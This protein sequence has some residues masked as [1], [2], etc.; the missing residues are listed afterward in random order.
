MPVMNVC[1]LA[2]CDILLLL[3]LDEQCMRSSVVTDGR[4]SMN[5]CCRDQAKRHTA[6]EVAKGETRK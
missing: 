4:L 3:N 5:V 2:P 1:Q 6:L